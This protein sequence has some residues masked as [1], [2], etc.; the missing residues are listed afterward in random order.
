MKSSRRAFIAAAATAPVVASLPTASA[1]TAA[2][3][4][5]CAII[6]GYWNLR[7]NRNGDHLAA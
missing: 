5:Y 6:P 7:F 1:I 2:L 4:R 3:P